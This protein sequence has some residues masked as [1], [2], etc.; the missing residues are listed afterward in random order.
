MDKSGNKKVIIAVDP[1]TQKCG[2]AVLDGDGNILEREI[3]PRS[4]IVARVKSLASEH[5]DAGVVVGGSTQGDAIAHDLSEQAGIEAV[6]IDEANSTDEARELFWKENKPGCLWVIFPA[7]F[8]PMPGPIDDYAAEIIG[9][10]F[11]SG[12]ARDKDKN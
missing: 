12:L 5:P 6:M 7:S 3:V 11:L 4:E 1:G 2:I 10:R 9:R 8:R